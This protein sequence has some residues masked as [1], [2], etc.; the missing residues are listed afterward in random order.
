MT[1]NI[2]FDYRFDAQG[3]FS[4]PLRK[5]TLEQAANIWE[6]Y[7]KDD[8]TAIP[9]G[10]SLSVPITYLTNVSG[11]GYSTG[12]TSQAVTLSQPIDDLLIFVYS[13]SLPSGSTTQ[14]VG[15]SFGQWQ[16]GSDRD[17]RYNGNNFE[18]WAGTIYFNSSS[19]FF[20]DQTS[21]T[22]ND[23][24]SNQ[25][26]FLTI[27]LHEIGHVLGF[28]SSSAFKN[29]IVGQGFNGAASRSL[30]GGQAIPLAPDL[31]HI[32]EGF[33]L[34]PS[35]EDLMDS[36]SLYGTRKLPS[37]LDTV[38]LRDIGYQIAIP[39]STLKD[40]LT[41][42]IIRFQNTDKPGTYL[43]VGQQE[44]ASIRQ[45]NRPVRKIET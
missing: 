10:E 27:A 43:F 44:A 22:S 37:T 9:A 24:T 14:G 25:S 45:N 34:S 3:F 17:I 23:I 12:T 39:D 28:G 19:N 33:A 41:T 31:S 11:T 26:D 13:L 30:Y 4:D 2:Q 20:F 1:F 7:I 35:S 16:V 40:K 5:N 32:K 8:F 18:P 21:N 36:S 15:G 6:S 29:Q 38:I 42:P